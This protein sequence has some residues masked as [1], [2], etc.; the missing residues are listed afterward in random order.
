[1]DVINMEKNIDFVA[2]R[3]QDTSSWGFLIVGKAK[4]I[5]EI[6]DEILGITKKVFDI[7][8]GFFIPTKIKYDMLFFSDDLSASEVFE[9]IKPSSIIQREIVSDTGISH[10]KFLEEVRSNETFKDKIKYIRRIEIDE[11]KTKF[12]LKGKDEY[13]DRNSKELYAGWRFDEISDRQ[14]TSD[15]IR[16]DISHSS[17]KGENQH[18]ESADPAYY[19]IVFWTDT[20][21]WFEK[22]EI[23]LA[24]RNRLRGALKKVYENFDVVHTLFLS[25][26]F[27]EKALK[28][29]IFG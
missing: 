23:G 10:H 9:L 27:S 15:P 6:S 5:S 17:L 3:P 18:V 14:P 2:Y 4:K 26:G 8:K 29:V 19:D 21:I 12:V 24:N 11:G 22:T 1:M 7:T 20:D 13:I 28:D 25:D 16:I